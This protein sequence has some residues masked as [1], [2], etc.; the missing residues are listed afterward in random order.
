MAQAFA[1]AS[2]A[3]RG[4]A[5]RADLLAAKA[6]MVEFKADVQTDMAALEKRVATKADLA[7]REI[8][9]ARFGYGLAFTVLGLNVV[10]MFG[11]LKLPPPPS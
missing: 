6:D 10:A 2:E 5:T 3:A 4:L 7:A 8:R 11:L 9:M 1:S